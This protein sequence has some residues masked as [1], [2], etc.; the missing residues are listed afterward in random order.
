VVY[1]LSVQPYFY[2]YLLVVQGKSV[3]AAG[4][5]TQ[6]FTF[7]A[8]VTSILTSITIKY[9]KHYKYF[10]TTGACI[11]LLG[12]VLM[13]RYR[14]EGVSDMFLIGC[15][16]CVGIGGGMLHVPAQ[17]GVQASVG[18]GEVGAVTAAF[19][20]I[21]E[22][23]GAVGSAVSGAI[24]SSNVPVKLAKYLP[25]ET[26]DQAAEIFGSVKVAST[27]YAMG[28][29]TRVAINLAYQETMTK[30][31]T[32]AVLV[33]IP[34]IPLS[35][36][37]ENYKLDEMDQHV[38]GTV[39]GNTSECGDSAERQPFAAAASSSSSSS[40][41]SLDAHHH[42]RHDSED[43]TSDFS[44]ATRVMASKS[45]LRSL[46]SNASLRANGV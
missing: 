20:T 17:L 23:G 5:I 44:S 32:V 8:T 29:P 14:V 28:T 41:S 11:Y 21:L 34:L 4:H 24:W 31:L 19:L 37:M 6:T 22:I 7:T 15:Q 43:E 35:L 38:K 1:Y 30:I 27:H 46:Q 26:R 39:I 40:S 25:P 42:R 45:N 36:M 13:L 18:H 3:S 10:I 9:T 16:V 2:S 12:V 33:C